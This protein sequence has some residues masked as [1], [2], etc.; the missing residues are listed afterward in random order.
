MMALTMW[1]ITVL[2]VIATSLAP[3]L[4]FELS[5]SL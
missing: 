3:A 5:K 1:M 2:T 4:M